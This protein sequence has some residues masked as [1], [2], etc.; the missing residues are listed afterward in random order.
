[1][2]FSASNQSFLLE[3]EHWKIDTPEEPAIPTSPLVPFV[4][5]YGVQK[6]FIADKQHLPMVSFCT[7]P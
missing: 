1:M 3:T 7:Y 5:E 2:Y 4:F 6:R